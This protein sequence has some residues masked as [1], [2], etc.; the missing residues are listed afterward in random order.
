MSATCIQRVREAGSAG[1][2]EE[3]Q[4]DFLSAVVTGDKKGA[5]KE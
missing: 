5:Q 4:P 3:A 2:A 1:S